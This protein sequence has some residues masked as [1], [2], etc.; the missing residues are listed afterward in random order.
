MVLI[1]FLNAENVGVQL[2][3]LDYFQRYLVI[4]HKHA[5]LEPSEEIATHHER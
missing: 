5:I 1:E 3:G 4:L 2:D